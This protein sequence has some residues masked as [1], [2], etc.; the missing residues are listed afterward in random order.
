MQKV[1]IKSRRPPITAPMNRPPPPPSPKNDQI[2][3]ARQ[4]AEA[5]HRA[6]GEDKGTVPLAVLHTVLVAL[7][8]LTQKR[9]RTAR[10][11]R[12]DDRATRNSRFRILTTLQH[13]HEAA[14]TLPRTIPGCPP[15]DSDVLRFWA[16]ENKKKYAFGLFDLWLLGRL[17]EKTCTL[18]K[19]RKRD[20]T[21]DAR[22]GVKDRTAAS[23]WYELCNTFPRLLTFPLSPSNANEP[24]SWT[25]HDLTQH[26]ACI[27]QAI[28]GKEI[29][30]GRLTQEQVVWLRAQDETKLLQRCKNPNVAPLDA[31]KLRTLD[32]CVRDCWGYTAL[33]YAT[34]KN[35][36]AH[37][38]ALIEHGGVD[39]AGNLRQRQ[40]RL[41]NRKGET[42][43]DIA[44]RK[45]YHE[46]AALLEKAAACD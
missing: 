28:D 39:L 38:Q 46:V 42:A 22:I 17:V 20:L 12:R 9:A 11:Q 41:E 1:H 29:V 19:K 37:V 33:M 4:W 32:V 24:A 27:E 30:G 5:E 23:K 14:F 31:A 25:L 15:S 26:I 45:G 2:T 16:Q 36:V 13:R 8:C 40:L 21:R 18:G 3:A 44:Q 43:A 7:A 10:K 34:R 35:A 6:H